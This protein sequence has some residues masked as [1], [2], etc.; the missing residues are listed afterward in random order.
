MKIS[1][2]SS[3]ADTNVCAEEEGG[4]VPAAPAEILLQ[5]VVK[6]MV[7]QLCPPWRTMWMQ[8]CT[9]IPWRR[10]SPKQVDAWKEAGR[11]L[12]THGQSRFPG[13][14]CDPAGKPHWSSLCLKECILWK[15]DPCYNSSIMWRTVAEGMDSCWR[16]S[17]WAKGM[18]CLS[19]SDFSS[20][21]K[22]TQTAALVRTRNPS[23]LSKNWKGLN[24]H[25]RH[26]LCLGLTQTKWRA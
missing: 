21:M 15:G 26:Y 23:L 22:K 19:V 9:C 1:E 7:K 16:P 24:T 11:D 17:W 2:R 4:G 6:T 8:R 18:W 20:N 13:G 10:T 14:T 25:W 3:S 5:P 12:Q